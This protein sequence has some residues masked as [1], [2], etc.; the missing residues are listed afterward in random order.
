MSQTH[1]HD[2]LQ[3]EAESNNHGGGGPSESLPRSPTP[4]RGSAEY[5]AWSHGP[6]YSLEHIAQQRRGGGDL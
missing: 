5:F 2:T 1:P 4:T 6:V 3:D